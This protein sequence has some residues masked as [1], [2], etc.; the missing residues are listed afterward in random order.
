M[1]KRLFDLLSVESYCSMLIERI[2]SAERKNGKKNIMEKDITNNTHPVK[3]EVKSEDLT[4][5]NTNEKN[6]KESQVVKSQDL[7]VDNTGEKN[8]VD[9]PLWKKLLPPS[10][11]VKPEMVKYS[12]LTNVIVYFCVGLV[13]LVM[14]LIRVNLS[15]DGTPIFDE[16]HYVP[17]A[18]QML[19]ISGGVEQ[20][21]G[22]G[23]VVHPPLGK[24]I[25]AGSEALF[26]YNPM[27]WRAFSILAGVIIILAITLSMH[28]LTGS[29]VAG[30]ATA[31]VANTEGI[32]FGMS[33]MGMLDI[34]LALFITLIATCIVM[35]ITSDTRGVPWHRRWWL[36]ASGVFCGLAMGI[37][38]S[39]VYYPA[40]C[41]IALVVTVAVVSRSFRET[42][43]ALGMGLIFYLV[44]PLGIFLLTWLPWFSSET[45]VYRHLAEAGNIEH[46]L[47]DWLARIMPDSVNS[48]MS[49]QIGIMKFHTNLKSGEGFDN[50]HPWESKPTD[51]LIGDRPMLFYQNDNNVTPVVGEGAGQIKLYLFA[52]PA[53]WWLFIPIVI[54][55]MIAAIWSAKT[56]IPWLI[57]LSGIA[58]GFIP[59]FITFDRQQYLFYVTSFAMFLSMGFI[60]A[61]GN[62]ATVLHKVSGE[63]IR[64]TTIRNVLYGIFGIIVVGVFFLYIPW[65][66]GVGVTSEVHDFLEFKDNWKPLEK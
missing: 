7:T 10:K 15:D 54:I 43:K 34:F 17:Q 55:G 44:V 16:K 25:I 26:G 57:V 62:I 56:R 45:S 2:I 28:R 4:L 30:V 58:V 9:K 61:L 65:Y 36:L 35:D 12:A 20:N 5:D 19:H 51:W 63:K 32:L 23:L 49:Y 38:V 33:R 59:W 41:G 46:P 8:Q 13:S 60:L 14:R 6:D 64:E 22:Y 40:L 66:Y 3:D 37:K 53:V 39:G 18:Q 52:N 21:P 48:F 1:P 47:P 11:T 42:L 29:L 27:G 24:W 50:V 31:V